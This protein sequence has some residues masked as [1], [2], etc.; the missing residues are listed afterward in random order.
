MPSLMSRIRHC[1]IC[2][3]AKSDVA[4]ERR[5]GLSWLRAERRRHTQQI[6]NPRR[7]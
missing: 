2:G 3:G 4:M 5:Y 7:K 6:I 1:C